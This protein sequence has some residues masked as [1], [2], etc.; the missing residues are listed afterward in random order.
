MEVPRLSCHLSNSRFA[1]G[2]KRTMTPRVLEKR[3]ALW[4]VYSRKLKKLFPEAKCALN[5]SNDWELMVA[6]QLSAQCTDKMVNR[7]T[8]DLFRK[9]RTLEDYIEA[10]PRQFEQDIFKTG[11]YRNKTKN[12]LAA[13]KMVK[14]KFHGKIPTTMHEILKIPG[15]A[16]KT[17]NVVLGTAHGVVEGIAA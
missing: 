2:I 11:F 12:I 5:F 14:E 6:V 8:P 16:R 13:A 15:V 17:A 3:K 7:V 10:L 4:K 9:Y 1:R